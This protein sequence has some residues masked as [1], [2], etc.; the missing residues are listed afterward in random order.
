MS[1]EDN[2]FSRLRQSR[3]QE[4]VDDRIRFIRKVFGILTFQLALTTLITSVPVFNPD[5]SNWILKHKALL[6]TS[7]ITLLVTNIAIFCVPGIARRVPTNYILLLLFTLSEA[8]TVAYTAARY[9]PR[10]VLLA[11]LIA[12]GVV[13]S[14]TLYALL[15]PSDFSMSGGSLFIFSSALAICSLILIFVPNSPFWNVLFSG[16]SIILF[17]FYL[18]YDVQIIVG[19][20][21]YEIDGDDYIIA[22]IIIYVDIVMLFVHLLKLIGDKK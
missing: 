22:A 2:Q 11:A 1:I 14:L 6:W 17:G 10:S 9:E 12:T 15:T 13:L 18:I 19:G 16:A 21:S 4:E 8:Y 20:G 5:A 7:L 3:P